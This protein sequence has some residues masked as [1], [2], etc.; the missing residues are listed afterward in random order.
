MICT[1]LKLASYLMKNNLKDSLYVRIFQSG[2]V[3]IIYKN[4]IKD[5]YGNLIIND[6]FENCK[7]YQIGNDFYVTTNNKLYLLKE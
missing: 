1:N 3:F 4:L 7:I 6:K 2:K 5:L